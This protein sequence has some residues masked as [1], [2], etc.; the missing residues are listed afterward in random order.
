MTTV[1]RAALDIAAAVSR[2]EVTA[3]E[4]VR[5]HLEAVAAR[6]TE[7]QA[8]ALVDP[9]G[10]LAAAEVV[11]AAIAVG[12]EP[13]PLAGVPFG[14]KDIIDVQGLPTGNGADHP[15]SSPATDD[16]ACVARL[17]RAGAI[18]LGKTVTTEYALFRP[19]PTRNP[20]D[21]TRTPGGSS[22]GSAAAVAAGTVPLAIGTQTAGSV[23]RPASF[24]GIVGAKPTVGV[25]PRGGVTLCSST[26]DTIGLLGSDV[27]GV[28][29][30]LSTM[31]AGA[32][33]D[34][35]GPDPGS[36][37][38]GY[39]RSFE[40][41]AL[42]ASTRTLLDAAAERL[43][44]HLDVREVTLPEAFVGL[45]E[46]QTTI[47]AVEVAD[48]LREIRDRYGDALSEGLHAFARLG[49][50]RRWGYDA[51]VVH[52][53]GAQAH[54]DEVFADVD[55]LLTPS[56]LGEAPPRDTTGDPLLC[57]QWT[58]LGTPVVAIPALRGPAGLP[59]GVQVVA[60]LRRDRVALDAA[61]V[62]ADL[63]T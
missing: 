25:V 28:A 23:I 1:G 20:H 6:E 39:C 21:V 24:C 59:V 50:S 7:L 5:E 38:V 49:A 8:W 48:H 19:G 31:S 41:P 57:R 47:M 16:A 9:D 46:A 15:P 40:W 53:A 56:V 4:V 14:V 55:V 26:L 10:A 43:A 63:L 12:R 30:G 45:A 3:V 33:A 27:A 11:D 62:I 44:G 54:L 34:G 22:S 35:E 58:L 52:A 42:E 61:A 29:A 51:A 37:R 18:P 2:R 17:R 36:L 32:T 13:L 60:Q